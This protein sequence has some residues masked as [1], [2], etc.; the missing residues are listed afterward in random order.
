MHEND[1]YRAKVARTNFEQ[2]N[3]EVFS[4]YARESRDISTST[5]ECIENYI[6]L[7]EQ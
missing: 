7:M 6:V 4:L 5:V 2:W 1:S 3:F